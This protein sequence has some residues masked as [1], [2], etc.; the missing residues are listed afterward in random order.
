ML[1]EPDDAH[2]ERVELRVRGVVDERWLERQG[3]GGLF[4]EKDRRHGTS[5]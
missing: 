3:S 5:E 4:E 2:V 1:V